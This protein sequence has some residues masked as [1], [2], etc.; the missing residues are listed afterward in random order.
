[1]MKKDVVLITAFKVNVIPGHEDCKISTSLYLLMFF[2]DDNTTNVL[3]DVW[4]L[5]PTFFKR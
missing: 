3:G 5:K 1:M 4:P 2:R